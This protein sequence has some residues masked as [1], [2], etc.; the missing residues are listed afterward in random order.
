MN[1]HDF[2][3]EIG[4]CRRAER[5]ARYVVFCD[6]PQ[7]WK[8][9]VSQTAVWKDNVS[10]TAVWNNNVSQIKSIFNTF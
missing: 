8:D 7:L 5:R 1:G 2:G 6:S 3:V 10:Q 4:V 9:N